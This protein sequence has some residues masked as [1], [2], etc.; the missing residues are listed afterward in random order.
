[1]SKYN[2]RND[3]YS[4]LAKIGSKYYKDS[5]Y[6][7]VIAG[8]KACRCSYGKA[9]SEMERQG[10][11]RGRGSSIGMIEEAIK[12]IAGKQTTVVRGGWI[13]KTV[14]QAERGLPKKGTFLI[15]QKAHIACLI[16]GKIFDWT[17]KDEGN[18]KASRKRVM[19]IS[20]VTE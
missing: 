5:G 9:F 14:A 13:G 11:K 7:G 10:R 6:C 19:M 16:D 15:Y 1:M 20:E 12:N 2:L 3:S 4:E 8:A 18:G 17:G